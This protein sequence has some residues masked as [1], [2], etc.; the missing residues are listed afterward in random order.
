MNNSVSKKLSEMPL[1]FSPLNTDE[2]IPHVCPLRF[3]KISIKQKILSLKPEIRL[4]T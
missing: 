1:R 3:R 4:K 2:I